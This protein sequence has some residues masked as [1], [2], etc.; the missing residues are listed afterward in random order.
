MTTSSETS[1]NSNLHKKYLGD[2]VERRRRVLL[3]S[4]ANDVM[5]LMKKCCELVLL[6]RPQP[7]QKLI[8]LL[9][10]RG[11]VGYVVDFVIVRHSARRIDAPVLRLLVIVR[12]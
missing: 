4:I 11:C 5:A 2:F 1:L 9:S 3:L 6:E 12:N 8:N 10:A 7:R